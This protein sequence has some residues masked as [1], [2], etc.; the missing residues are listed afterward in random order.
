MYFAPTRAA[1]VIEVVGV[2]TLLAAA[3]QA[4]TTNR[5]AEARCVGAVEALFKLAGDGAPV[6]V[7]GVAVVAE[8]IVRQEAITTLRVA[9][10]GLALTV[11]A[12]E[13]LAAIVTTLTTR[14]GVEAG[15]TLLAVLGLDDAVATGL[16]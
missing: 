3:D 12:V 14:A 11:V 4:I 9:V 10:A 16:E 6:A 1:V 8:L 5:H 15:V 2:I 13:N 7:Q